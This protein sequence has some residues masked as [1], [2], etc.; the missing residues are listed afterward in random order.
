PRPV[1]RGLLLAL[2]RGWR[3]SMRGLRVSNRWSR[4]WL[5][6]PARSPTRAR[7]PSSVRGRSSRSLAN[8]RTPTLSHA[9]LVA[10]GKPVAQREGRGGH[11]HLRRDDG[12]DS[13]PHR[14]HPHDG[15]RLS[16]PVAGST[17]G[18]A[19]HRLPCGVDVIALTALAGAAARRTASRDVAAQCQTRSEDQLDTV[20]LDRLPPCP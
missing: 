2:L 1:G 12:R 5:C 6:A 15:R 4:S 18:H 11:H 16:A 3:L 20:S 10:L 17:W 8:A 14:L 7:P 9:D 13:A 19:R